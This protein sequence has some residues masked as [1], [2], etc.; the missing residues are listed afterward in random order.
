MSLPGVDIRVAGQNCILKIVDV[1]VFFIKLW[2]RALRWLAT[3]YVSD[4]LYFVL[5]YEP[6]GFSTSSDD[7]ISKHVVNRNIVIVSSLLT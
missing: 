5:C 1:K 4:G 2:P 7:V 6:V 3:L